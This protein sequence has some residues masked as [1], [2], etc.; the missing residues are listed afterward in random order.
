MIWYYRNNSVSLSRKFTFKYVPGGLALCVN[1]CVCVQ[2]INMYVHCTGYPIY[3]VRMYALCY[4]H[5]CVCMGVQ[6][7]WTIGVELMCYVHRICND[8]DKQ[9]P[10]INIMQYWSVMFCSCLNKP[11][12]RENTIQL[13]CFFVV[14]CFPSVGKLIS[15][16]TLH[17]SQMSVK[18]WPWKVFICL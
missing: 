13:H 8:H 3:N 12:R 6:G 17:N 5:T 11:H 9:P 10:T 15:H 14:D 1:V 18:F 4:V 7:A 2:G 16:C